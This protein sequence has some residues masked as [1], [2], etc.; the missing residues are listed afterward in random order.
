MSSVSEAQGTGVFFEVTDQY[1]CRMQRTVDGVELACRPT[2]AATT[3]ES[4][5]RLS[6]G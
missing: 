5:I 4:D 1:G 6:I 2:I 3:P